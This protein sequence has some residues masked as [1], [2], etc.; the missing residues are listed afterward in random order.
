[1]ADGDIAVIG[2]NYG[3]ARTPGWVH[4]LRANPDVEVEHAGRTVAATA[5]RLGR[6][7]AE[8]VWSTAMDT[9]AGYAHYRRWA[10]GREIT[11]WLLSPR[12]A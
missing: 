5:R 7:A 10:A 4:N 1:P 8:A 6:E 2:S 9:Y 3:T 12:D 11:V